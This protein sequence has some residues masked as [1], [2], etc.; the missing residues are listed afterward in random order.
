MDDTTATREDSEIAFCLASEGDYDDVMAISGGIYSGMDY[1]PARYHVWMKEPHRLVFLGKRRGRVVGPTILVDGGET[2]IVE[3]LR[4]APEERGRGVA[5][6]IQRHVTQFIKTHYPRVRT[7]R[8]T[9][10][11]NPGP[12]A[13]AKFRVLATRAI[14]TQR[15][16]ADSV[17]RFIDELGVRVRLEGAGKYPPAPPP[18]TLQR[19]ELR[20]L[21][22]S[23]PG[24]IDRLLPAG[25]IIQDWQPLRPTAGNLDTLETRPLSWAVDRQDAPAAL[26]LC[27]APYPIPQ[28]GGSLRLNLDV[29]G[30]DLAAARRV[31]VFQMERVRGA[32]GS[33]MAVLLNVYSDRTLWEGLRELCEGAGVVAGGVRRYKEYWEQLLLEADF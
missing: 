7:K 13:L 12:Q 31:L 9:R 2:V 14:L 3:G 26:V 20:S 27:T 30:M 1:L 32:L 6:L 8:L 21:M 24:A 25:T 11:D 4:V 23:N 17:D 18:V 5:G 15:C 22:L 16:E 19:E 10:G 28:G 29:F 33:G